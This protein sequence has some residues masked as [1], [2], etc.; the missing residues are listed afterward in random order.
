[1]STKSIWIFTVIALLFG[2]APTVDKPMKRDPRKSILSAGPDN[3]YQP[4]TVLVIATPGYLWAANDVS[5]VMLSNTS[6][7][8]IPLK[9]AY[10]ALLYNEN[11]IGLVEVII[12]LDQ[13]YETV[14]AVCRDKESSKVWQETRALNFGGGQERLAKDMVGGLLGKV[15]GK[16]CL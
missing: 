16:S 15:R 10:D 12:S 8:D 3:P 9:S 1:M 11:V 5:Q 13:F 6:P 2:C 4:E 7:Q 14:S